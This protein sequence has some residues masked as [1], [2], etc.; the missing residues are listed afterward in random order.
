VESG[1]CTG[2]VRPSNIRADVLSSTHEFQAAAP[3]GPNEKV[4][5][6]DI[7]HRRAERSRA[8]VSPE[9]CDTPLPLPRSPETT[10]E[11][12][13]FPHLL[14]ASQTCPDDPSC[15]SLLLFLRFQTSNMSLCTS[16]TERGITSFATQMLERQAL[17]LTFAETACS[18][19]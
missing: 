12:H 1:S 19:S 2:P 5:S 3:H 6:L 9:A 14:S 4:P 10:F 8:Y 17:A 7:V 11:T 13:L 18:P 16:N 15:Y